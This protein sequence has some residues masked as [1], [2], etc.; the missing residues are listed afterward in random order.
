[1]AR[2]RGP[3]AAAVAG[4]GWRTGLAAGIGHSWG[5]AEG[6]D[7][8][9]GL[10]VGIGSRTGPLQEPELVQGRLL[11]LQERQRPSSRRRRSR[12]LR[13]IV[14]LCFPY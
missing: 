6:I 14:S 11:L 2:R 4:I 10:E 1:V 13:W 9:M 7:W 3:A 8:R 12:L 5:L